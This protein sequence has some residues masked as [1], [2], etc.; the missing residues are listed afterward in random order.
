VDVSASESYINSLNPPQIFGAQTDYDKLNPGVRQPLFIRPSSKWYPGGSGGVPAVAGVTNQDLALTWSLDELGPAGTHDVQNAGRLVVTDEGEFMGWDYRVGLNASMSTR[1]VGWQT[2]FVTVPGVYKGIADGVLNPFGK[3]DAAGQAYLDSISTDGKTYRKARVRYFGPDFNL[4]RSLTE[5]AGGSLA[6]A[7]GGDLHREI[8]DDNTGMI[9]NEVVYKVSGTPGA[10]S[11]GARTI[12]GLYTEIDAPVSKQLDLTLGVRADHFSDFGNTV[13]PKLSARWQPH[14]M[15][16]FRG[17]ASTAFRAPTLPELYGTPRTKVPSTGK[18]DD[19]LLCPSA[20]PSIPGTGS[21]TK[22]PKY[23]GLNLDPA[24]V[25]NTNLT[26]LTGA[27]PELQ[28]EKARMVTVGIVV[29]PVNNLML[30]LDVWDVKMK[31]T[32]AQVAEATI[33]DD[34]S[35]HADLFVR[36]PD[37]TLNYIVDTRLNMGGVHTRG[38]DASFRYTLPT[39]N[40]GKFGVSMDGTF[41][42]QYESQNEEGG[43]W[44]GS[45]GHP[46]ALATGATSAN[47]YVFR[48]KHNLRLSWGIGKFGATLS[49]AYTSSYIDTNALPTQKPG[50]PY[51]NVIAPFRLYNLSTSYAWSKQLRMSVGVNNLLD[52]DPPLS[53]ARLGSRVVFAN[54]IS[55]P[56]GRTWNVRADYTF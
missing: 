26:V 54:N 6:V 12:G 50:Q 25:C 3:Q 56:I 2:G 13:N 48:W 19:P 28:P 27:N 15:V 55:K 17:T 29:E 32:I 16:M 23:A 38:V 1:R 45:V 37:G 11:S 10:G 22:D 41:V 49:Q 42:D 20:T 52:S 4:S 34:V 46:G 30:G 39:K 14:K 40:W 36:N 35:R 18:W 5:L 8:Y 21:L 31:G 43:P 24:R 51:Y 33:F 44:I 7:V 9:A 47:T 53:N